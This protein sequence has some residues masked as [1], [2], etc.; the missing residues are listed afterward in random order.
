MKLP[1]PL[2]TNKRP[3]KYSRVIILQC[4]FNKIICACA[5]DNGSSAAGEVKMVCGYWSK[6]ILSFILFQEII[7][8][9]DDEDEEVKSGMSDDENTFEGVK[10]DEDESIGVRCVGEERGED[11]CTT[12]PV[13]TIQVKN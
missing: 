7:V 10:N 12:S 13:K 1:N 4:A 9:S 5:V 2:S 3:I 8:I 11:S 6:C